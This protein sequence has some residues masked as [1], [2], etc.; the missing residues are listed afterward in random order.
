MSTSMWTMKPKI[1]KEGQWWF[2]SYYKQRLRNLTCDGDTGRGFTPFIA[3][4]NWKYRT[5]NAS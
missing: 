4:Y 2:C 1:W 3:W 5:Y